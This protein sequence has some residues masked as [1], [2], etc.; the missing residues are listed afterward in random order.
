MDDDIKRTLNSLHA[1]L[2]TI[3]RLS[4]VTS[5]TLP[6]SEFSTAGPTQLRWRKVDDKTMEVTIVSE[7]AQVVEEIEAWLAR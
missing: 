7:D 4:G 3:M 6:L 1:I 5:L 2:V